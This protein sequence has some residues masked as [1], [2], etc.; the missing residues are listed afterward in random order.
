MKKTIDVMKEKRTVSVEVKNRIKAFNKLK[1]L[2]LNSLKSGE[3]T[4]PEI[5]KEL[6]LDSDAVTYNLMT[7]LK[8]GF[9]VTGEIDDDDEY[10]YYK[11]KEKK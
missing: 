6:E 11:L 7:L 8:Y 3:K 2:I 5:A 10:Y 4:I 1:K 9:I